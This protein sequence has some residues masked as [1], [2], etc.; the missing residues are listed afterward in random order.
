MN[1][2]DQ[3]LRA[4]LKAHHLVFSHDGMP[5]YRRQRRGKTFRFLLPDGTTLKDREERRRILSLAIPPAY[6]NVWICPIPNG[7]LQATGIDQ[8]TRKQYRYHSDWAA[9]SANRKFTDLATFA[10]SLPSLRAAVTTALHRAGFDRERVVAGIVA[11]LDTTGYRIGNRR[12]VRENGSYGL[13]TLLAKHL[14]QSD[15]GWEVRFIGKA[16]QPHLARIRHHAINHLISELH[17]LPGQHL[18]RYEDSAGDWHNVSTT[19]VNEWLKQTGGGDFTAKQFRT[20]NATVRCAIELAKQ[21]PG[22]TKTAIKQAE[23][24]AIRATAERFRHTPATC[25]KYYIHPEIFRAFHNGKLYEIM[26]KRPP[27]FRADPAAK[28]RANERKILWLIEHPAPKK[29]PSR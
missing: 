11:L 16:G 28:L 9:L 17:E 18:F 1:Q 12:Y 21:P 2:A 14:K 25:K 4:E 22:D 29:R 26:K 13:A 8:R 5:G 3:A 23:V 27:L 10:R 19:E 15:Q 20:W 7:H 6:E 24:A